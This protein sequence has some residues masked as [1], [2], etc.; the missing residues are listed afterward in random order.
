EPVHAHVIQAPLG[1]GVPAPAELPGPG[2]GGFPEEEVVLPARTVPEPAQWGRGGVLEEAL[3]LT[4]QPRP[5]AEGGVPFGQFEED[6]GA[7]AA[8]TGVLEGFP[9]DFSAGALVGFPVGF[10]VG[11]L[12]GIPVGFRAGFL[13]GLPVSRL[14][15]YLVSRLAGLLQLQPQHASTLG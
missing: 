12:V 1:Q 2:V 14:A 3:L 5:G 15:G 8:G 7:H 6:F 4:G 11:A 10:P 13:V 9:A